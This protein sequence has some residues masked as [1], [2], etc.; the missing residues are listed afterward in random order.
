MKKIVE[1]IRKKG[2]QRYTIYKLD[3]PFPFYLLNLDKLNISLPCALY[4]E[5]ITIEDCGPIYSVVFYDEAG[6]FAAHKKFGFTEEK[7]VIEYFNELLLNTFQ[8]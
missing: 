4:F 2:V 8:K 5:Y 6:V 1:D 3:K 7:Y